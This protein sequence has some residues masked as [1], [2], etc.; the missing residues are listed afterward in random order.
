M[1]QIAKGV[2]AGFALLGAGPAWTA[3]YS[4]PLSPQAQQF[5]AK[6][7]GP[8][9]ICRDQVMNQLG[10]LAV[11]AESFCLCEI[12]VM[13]RNTSLKELWV[14]NAAMFGSELQRGE[15]VARAQYLIN[16]LLPERKRVCG[17]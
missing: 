2:I 8:S 15:N 13:A 7:S 6:F 16:R 5:E 11:G 9:A 10:L 1:R 14:L 17:Y 4:A 3:D 12:D